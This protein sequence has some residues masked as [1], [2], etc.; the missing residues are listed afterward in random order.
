MISLDNS[1]D[2]VRDGE[3]SSDEVH[4]VWAYVLEKVVR[5]GGPFA[6]TD[7]TDRLEQ[8]VNTATRLFPLGIPNR[9]EKWKVPDGVQVSE[10]PPFLRKVRK[11][12]HLLKRFTSRSA[13]FS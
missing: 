2:V 1:K 11:S 10:Y 8:L 3:L 13:M 5:Q 7:R 9:R 4:G 12:C 6:G